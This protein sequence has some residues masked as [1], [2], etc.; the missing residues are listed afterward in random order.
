MSTI[1]GNELDRSEEATMRQLEY[2]ARLMS[3]RRVSQPAA[4]KLIEIL[5]E[6]PEMS[7]SMGHN[8][9]ILHAVRNR[10]EREP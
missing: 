3:T 1:I 7:N 8:K 9:D 2:I 10:I 4:G 6:E 5:L